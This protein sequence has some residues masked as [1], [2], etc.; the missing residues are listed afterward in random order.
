MNLNLDLYTIQI[1]PLA[2]PAT[3]SAKYELD[4]RQEADMFDFDIQEK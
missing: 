3:Y 4:L 2:F 1:G